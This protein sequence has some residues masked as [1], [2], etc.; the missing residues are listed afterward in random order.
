VALHDYR[1]PRCR[2]TVRDQY[3]PIAIRASQLRP[4][5]PSCFLLTEW[6]PKVAAMD[7]REP[8]QQF[9][10]WVAN[11]DGSQRQVNVGSV[12]QM[13]QIERETEQAHRNGEGQPLR[14]RAW[15]NDRG[16]QDVNTFGPDPAQVARE[17]LD[18]EIAALGPRR[19]SVDPLRA[20]GEADADLPTGPGVPSE[21]ITP[22]GGL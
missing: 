1:C 7:A 18:R 4:I 3:R 16:N 17:T 2:T 9:P 19:G 10:V 6:V 13:R 22:L 21:G 14:F 8:F 12:H 11:P 15:N 5:C 20:V